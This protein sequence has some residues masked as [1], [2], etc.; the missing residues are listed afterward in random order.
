MVNRYKQ[1]TKSQSCRLHATPNAK[2]TCYIT[3]HKS[4]NCTLYVRILYLHLQELIPPCDARRREKSGSSVQRYFWLNSRHQQSIPSISLSC[5]TEY[6]PG[7][8]VVIVPSL[9]SQSILVCVCVMHWES[10]WVNVGMKIRLVDVDTSV[11]VAKLCTH[12]YIL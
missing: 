5:A 6:I 9:K 2:T 4:H 7:R 8:S 1:H 11:T 12:T 10:G 3:H